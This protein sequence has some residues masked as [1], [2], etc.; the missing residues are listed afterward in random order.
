MP[1][2]K[3]DLTYESYLRLPELLSLQTPQSNPPAHDELQFII[4]HQSYELWF[5]LLLYEVRTIIGH[6]RAGRVRQAIWLIRR[7]IEIE[8]VMVQQVQVLE[9]MSPTHFLE[10]RDL[11]RP[12]S[13]LQSLQ[14]RELEFL[15]GL[16]DERFFEVFAGS[17]AS[18]QRL[19]AAYDGPNLWSTFCELLHSR[20][21]ET[22]TAA[23]QERAVERIY[24]DPRHL[25][26]HQ[27][28]EV[29]VEY[30]EQ[31]CIWRSRHALMAERMVGA[32]PGTGDAY[33]GKLVGRASFQAPGVRYLQGRV[34]VH[35]FPILWDVR[36]QLGG[37]PYD[38]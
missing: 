17:G 26:L 32:K 10:F 15:S 13:G 27:L 29:M 36:T 31:F 34:S 20:G 6:L 18:R 22:D 33:T 5:R 38:T 30:D 37:G 28:C 25:D 21:F 1:Q 16:R 12:A 8:R 11:L 19:Q 7:L 35:F 24:T 4:V 3:P 23:Q 14:F 9:T 2:A